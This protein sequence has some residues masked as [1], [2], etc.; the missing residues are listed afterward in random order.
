[1]RRKDKPD[2]RM[3]IGKVVQLLLILLPGA[4]RYNHRM[5]ATPGLDQRQRGA[6]LCNLYHPVEPRIPADTHLPPQPPS[7]QQ[8]PRSLGLDEKMRHAFQHIPVQPAIPLEKRLIRPEYP[9]YQQYRDISFFKLRQEII[10]VVI[11]DPQHQGRAHQADEPPRIPL[12][13]QRQVVDIVRPLI[14]FFSGI[15]RRRK[16]SQHNPGPRRL[17]AQRFQDRSALLELTKRRTMHPDHRVF[18]AHRPRP[19]AGTPLGLTRPRHPRAAEV[20][21]ISARIRSKMPLRPSNHSLAF[22]FQGA[23]SRIPTL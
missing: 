12:T 21:P 2:L 17:P 1:M 23:T 22:R 6:L 19:T 9:R 10:P 11:F 18:P 5:P 8:S 4:A 15:A 20:T 13:I 16:E 3:R 14:I 7:I